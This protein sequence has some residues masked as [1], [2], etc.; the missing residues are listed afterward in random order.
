MNLRFQTIKSSDKKAVLALFKDA[1][2]KIEKKKIDHWQYWKNPPIEKVQWVEEGIA[3]KEFF[4]I[5]TTE[6]ETIGMVRILEDDLMYWGEQSD[7][8]KYIH[9]LVVIEKYEG[10]GIGELIIKKVEK[11]AKVSGFSYL[12]LDSDAKNPKL[13]NYYEKQGF[14]KVGVREL[15]LSTYILYQKV[16]K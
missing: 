11:E 10:Q 5:K 12:R 1:A 7:K 9:S 3:N 14:Q 15:S 2:D 16:L 4:F 6:S 8:S 13:C